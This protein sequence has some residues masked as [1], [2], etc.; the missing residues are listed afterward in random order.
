MRSVSLPIDSHFRCPLPWWDTRETHFVVASGEEG[1]GQ[2]T[3]HR[4]NI[5]T[6]YKTAVPGDAPSRIVG[7]WFIGV[8]IAGG[9]PAAAT[10]TDVAIVDGLSRIE[11]L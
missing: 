4:R 11:L 8:S 9:K 3:S 6:D 1:L 5:L 2:W 10:F 7:V